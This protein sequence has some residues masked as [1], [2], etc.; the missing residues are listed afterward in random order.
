MEIEIEFNGGFPNLCAGFLAVTIN[1]KRWVFESHALRSGGNVWFDRDWME[2]VESGP[3]TVSE[4][5][6]DFPED[7]KEEVEKEINASIPWGCCGGCV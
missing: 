6:D 5:P 7:L 2:H 3:W 4:W 1:E